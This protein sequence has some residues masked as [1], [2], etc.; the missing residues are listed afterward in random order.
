M[1]VASA[2][3]AGA[4]PPARTNASPIVPRL[5]K[6][7]LPALLVGALVL[8]M[9]L[10]VR[11]ADPP[12]LIDARLALFDAYQRAAPRPYTPLPVRVVD[13]DDASLERLGQWPWPRSQVA[14]LIDRLT[15]LDAAVIALDMVFAEPDR[16]SPR[17]LADLWRKEPAL[18]AVAR[19]LETLPDFDRQLAEAMARSRV[20]TGFGLTDAAGVRAPAAKSGLAAIGPHP[21][22]YLRDFGGAVAN[23]PILE[24]AAAATA[25]SASWRRAMR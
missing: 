9:V 18:A 13:I 15:A 17:H 25:A 23:L 10:G 1:T 7:R 4:L 21:R 2:A 6:G 3:T 20:V 22:R 8:L 5:R 24:E 16:L 12:L 11:A 19:Q 14:Q